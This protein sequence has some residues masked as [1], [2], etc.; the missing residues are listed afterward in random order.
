MAVSRFNTKGFYIDSCVWNTTPVLQ[1]ESCFEY[2]L[3]NQCRSFTI[4][5]KS[6]CIINSCK[7]LE[8]GSRT[9][10]TNDEVFTYFY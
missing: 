10:S 6:M 1:L 3:N 2:C 8:S 9:Y 5:T 7:P 4:S